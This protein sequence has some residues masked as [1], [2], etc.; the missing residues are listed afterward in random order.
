MAENRQRCVVLGGGGHAAVVI[1]A[2]QL[3][4]VQ[5]HGILDPN[6]ELRGTS[7]MGVVVLGGDELLSEIHN[8]GA[9]SFVLGIGSVGRSPRRRELFEISAR[10]RLTPLSAVHPTA[11]VS[12]WASVGEGSVVL[13][14]AVL[15]ATAR[16][17]LNVI[18]NTGAIV[19]HGCVIGDHSHIASG[20][21]ILGDVRIGQ[22]AF[23]GAGATVKQ[24]V[25][26]GDRVVIGAGAVVLHD[27]APDSTFV[28]V[29]ARSVAF[30]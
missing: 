22:E 7:M 1:D 8:E 18:I 25:V 13:S 12:K 6:S 2:L 15:N 11:S 24:G 23:I 5:V 30:E 17:G 27:V 26:I 4:G 20:A 19:E 29:P 14:N 3:L 10:S 16:V 9:T 21:R 28:G